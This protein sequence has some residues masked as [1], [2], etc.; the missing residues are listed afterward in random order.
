MKKPPFVAVPPDQI[1]AEESIISA[2]LNDNE[3]LHEID[4]RPDEFY[5]QNSRL[6]Y[7]AMAGMIGA[8]EAADLVTVA[9]R[10]G[11]DVPMSAISHYLD[12]VPV[13][14]NIVRHAEI[15]RQGAQR[16]Q[17][18]ALADQA[19]QMCDEGADCSA[20]IAHIQ[21]ISLSDGPKK[22]PS[23]AAIAA[24]CI[25]RLEET[26]ASDTPPGLPTGFSDFDRV[27]GGLHPTDLILIAGRPSMGKTS[28]ML[29]IIRNL[30]FHSIPGLTQSFEMSDTQ[31]GNRLLS[32]VGGIDSSLFR[33]GKVPGHLWP[34]IHH[35]ADTVAPMPIWVEDMSGMTISQVEVTAR[36]YH[37][38]HGI[39]YLAIDYLQ[40]FADWSPDNPASMPDITRR[41][42][43]LAKSLEIPVIVLSQL[44]RMLEQRSSKVPML[45]DL[46]DC[47]SIEQDADLVLFPYRASV[48]DKKIPSTVAQLIAA[49]NRN[50][51]TGTFDLAW[52]EEHMRYYDPPFGDCHV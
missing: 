13:S 34:D 47:G 5:W 12:T 48:Y 40:L 36:K 38:L 15:V 37:R 21:D 9:H 25:Q 24:R 11:S 52:S 27:M 35:A 4:L 17:L 6:I 51:P 18:K 33:H 26:T 29:N 39:R 16:R 20:I 7:A 46:R 14:T 32:D 50:G 49:K 44:N 8:G 23:M 22:D 10:L 2:I 30:G 28:L 43:G 31:L 45:S 1:A 42:K 19:S 3:Q 41:L